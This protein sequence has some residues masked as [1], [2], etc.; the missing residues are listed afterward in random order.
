[1]G[2]SLYGQFKVI[3]YKSNLIVIEKN[4]SGANP[5]REEYKIIEDD[6][7]YREVDGIA[8]VYERKN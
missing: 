7:I 2:E 5:L 3:E 8:E 1:M 6:V 4:Y